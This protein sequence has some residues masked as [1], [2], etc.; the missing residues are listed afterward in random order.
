MLD[1]HI[2]CPLFVF[3]DACSGGGVGRGEERSG[4]CQTAVSQQSGAFASE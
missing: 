3:S 2:S 4:D 1:S